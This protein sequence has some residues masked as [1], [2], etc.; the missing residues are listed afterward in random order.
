MMLVLS[1]KRDES[2]V[3]GDNI[4]VTVLSVGNGRVKL[5]IRAPRT[6]SVLRGELEPHTLDCGLE[7]VQ[8]DSAVSATLDTSEALS[9][10]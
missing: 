3:I 1:R 6:V 10:F 5:G 2:V 9:V 8:Q 4:E 7:L